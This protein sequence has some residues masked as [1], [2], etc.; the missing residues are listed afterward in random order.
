MEVKHTVDE[1]KS[2]DLCWWGGGFRETK[3]VFDGWALVT[4]AGVKDGCRN[5]K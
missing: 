5:K 2:I 1:W 4:G 3:V